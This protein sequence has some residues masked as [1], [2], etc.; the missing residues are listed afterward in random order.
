MTIFAFKPPT[1]PIYRRNGDG[2][3]DQSQKQEEVTGVTANWHDRG[4]AKMK[5]V[6][7]GKANCDRKLSRTLANEANPRR[8]R[9]RAPSEIAAML[10]S[11]VVTVPGCSISTKR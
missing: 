10:S 2:H 1:L 7:A 5:T 9:P 4:P 6:A 11:T 3:D 8:R